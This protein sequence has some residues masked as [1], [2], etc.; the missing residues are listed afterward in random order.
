MDDFRISATSVAAGVLWAIGAALT[1]VELLTGIDTGE[2]GIVAAA[3]GGVL[4]IRGYFCRLACRERKAFEL[5]REYESG[6]IHSV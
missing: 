4:T 6:R 5:G 3:G 2:V 1:I